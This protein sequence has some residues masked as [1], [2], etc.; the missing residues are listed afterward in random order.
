MISRKPIA[1]CIALLAFAAALWTARPASAQEGDSGPTRIVVVISST[2]ALIA[3]LEHMVVDLA[4]EEDKWENSVYPNID[5]FLFGV[6]RER[7]I[8][9]DQLIDGEGARRYQMV[10]PV[11]DL[12]EFIEDNLDP[13]GI[14]VDDVKNDDTLYELSDVF[15]GWM[16]FDNGYVAFAEKDFIN[17]LPKE[18]DEVLGKHDVLLERGYDIGI[19]LD[20][21]ETSLDERRD[22]FAN[23]KENVLAGVKKRPDETKEAYALRYANSENSIETLEQIY[24]ESEDITVGLIVDKE[25]SEGRGDLRLIP[26]AET[27]LAKFI[28]TLAEEPSHFAGFQAAEN[29]I[30]SGRMNF[31]LDDMLKEQLL[32]GYE[33]SKPVAH[34]RIDETEGITDDQK[35]ARK[36]ISDTLFDLFSGIQEIS[37]WDGF[38]Q[39]TPNDSGLHTGIFAGKTAEGTK[40]DAIVELLPKGHEGF[41]SELNVDEAG[42]VSI[43]K[44]S[45]GD[46]YPNAFKEFFGDEGAFYVGT[47]KDAVWLS[48][49]DGALDAMKEGVEAVAAGGG[50]ESDRT[51]LEADLNLLPILKLMYQ[52]RQDGDFDL[53]QTLNDAA[54][55]SSEPED[56]EE[57]EDSETAQ[58]LKDFEWREAAIAA[59]AGEN[60]K[61]HILLQRSEEGDITGEATSASGILK[62]IGELIAKFADENLGG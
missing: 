39:V 21:T 2:D 60:D 31:A 22:G 11:S 48:I 6:D 51:I 35:A 32:E 17:E 44:V 15:E 61:I 14:I 36:E 40:V 30:L 12:D 7:P 55:E 9:F 56:G 47:S 16:R 10:I 25:K 29:A 19:Q 5:I 24:V 41:T 62:T 8:R 58:M 45:M 34:Q 23:F 28:A 26:V 1:S 4:G 42:G 37:V 3:D 27:E 43:H 53:M 33:L 54:E 20:N 13:I 38:V 49:G 52:L 46:G 57:E 50:A 59:L 18:F